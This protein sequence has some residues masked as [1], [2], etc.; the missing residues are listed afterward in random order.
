VQ[1][2]KASKIAVEIAA[3]RVRTSVPRD[4]YAVVRTERCHPDTYNDLFI[5]IRSDGDG[6]VV[7][8]WLASCGCMQHV[9]SKF[10]FQRRE[11]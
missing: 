4:I 2:D 8:V 6:E 1:A 10:E 11:N 5:Y 3:G 7:T 9:G